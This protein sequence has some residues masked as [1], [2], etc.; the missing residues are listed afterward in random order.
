MICIDMD[1]PKGCWECPLV[2]E[3]LT[4]NADIDGLEPIFR[5]GLSLKKLYKNKRR[6]DCP[7]KEIKEN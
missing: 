1:M 2:K 4:Y 3:S 6:K 7:L 5:C